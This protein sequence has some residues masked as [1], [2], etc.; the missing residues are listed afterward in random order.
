MKSTHGSPELDE[1]ARKLEAMGADP[2]PT[3]ADLDPDP[4]PD[5]DANYYEWV[6]WWYRQ[7]QNQEQVR[8]IER[9]YIEAMQRDPHLD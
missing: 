9:S 7:P 2:G 3:F 6:K 1:D 5:R 8:E 4:E